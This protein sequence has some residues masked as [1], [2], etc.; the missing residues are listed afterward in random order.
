VRR[1]TP[2]QYRDDE[3]GA[4]LQ[5]SEPPHIPTISGDDSPPESIL[6]DTGL[7][8]DLASRGVVWD[9]FCTTRAI[10]RV[11]GAILARVRYEPMPGGKEIVEHMIVT[12]GG[13]V[14]PVSLEEGMRAMK[15]M[16]RS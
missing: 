13:A 12:R 8:E 9:R 3:Y 2:N 5:A 10:W 15:A 1:Y 6:D 16:E 11:E 4:P 7:Y 14:E